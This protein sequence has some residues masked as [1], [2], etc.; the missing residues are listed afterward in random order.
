MAPAD[1]SDSL[2]TIK[3]KADNSSSYQITDHLGNVRAV[4]KENVTQ[5]T[6]MA[7]SI[8]RDDD[9][10]GI[11]MDPI[12]ESYADYYPFGEQL[13]ER[14]ST[15]GYRY[16]FQG[17]EKDPETGME[18]FQLRLWDGRI[19]RWLSVDPMNE[20]DSPY[21]GMGNNP[22]NA[23]DPDGGDI[24]VLNHSTG[25]SGFG[26]LAL[27]IGND[28]DGWRFISKEGRKRTVNPKTGKTEKAGTELFGG[29]SE[30][31]IL[32]SP[33]AENIKFATLEEALKNSK[34]KNY[35]KAI[36]FK[37]NKSQDNNAFNAAKKS[38]A[39]MYHVLLNN[40]ADCASKGLYAAGLNGAVNL[41][42]DHPEP[43]KR[44]QDIQ[45]QNSPLLWQMMNLNLF[46][47]NS[48][49]KSENT[50]NF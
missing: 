21:L 34:I 16:A 19:G 2:V 14:N 6:G 23:I 4:I 46:R 32:P 38:A 17:Q 33:T 28:K 29:A 41:K 20:F 7:L 45:N 27:L 35:D 44:F 30:T 12:I 48:I 24:I 47:S 22:V 39:T 43:N 31:L 3:N 26:H 25:A 5:L 36:R 8:I 10:I 37:T 49:P 1:A 18:A 13:P 15:S 50:S 40:C 42:S 9:P 11:R